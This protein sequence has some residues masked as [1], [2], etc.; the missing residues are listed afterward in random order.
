MMDR[1]KETL[2]SP[3]LDRTLEALKGQRSVR[4]LENY[5]SSINKVKEF[6]GNGWESLTMENITKCWTDKY[7]A[8]LESRH[9]DKPQTTDFYLRTFRAVYGHAL[10]LSSEGTD[11][12][13]F[14]GHRTGGYFPAKRALRKEEMQRLLSPDLRQ[15]LP[16]NQREA[17][18]VL[19]FILYARGMVFKD[20]YGL[21]WRM[22]TDGHIRYRRSKTDV[23]I[24]VEIVPELE[25]IMERYH[26]EDSPF[27]FPFLHETRKGCL[28]K[29]LPEESALRRI[30][31]TARMIGRK[32]GLSVPLTTYVLRH[33]WATL[34]LEDS[35]PVELISQCMG[36]TSI[37]T[38]QIYLSRISSHKVDIAVSGMYDRMLRKP[39]HKR[40]ERDIPSGHH[41]KSESPVSQ[42]MENG[43]THPY[44]SQ[45]PEN[46]KC[47]FLS[48]KE[49]SVSCHVNTVI[50][51]AAKVYISYIC[52]KFSSAFFSV[53]LDISSCL[54]V[55]YSFHTI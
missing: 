15:T 25:E 46:E 50:F 6:A 51:F 13:P 16:E 26:R 17:L 27:V 41:R 22:V 45:T 2:L 21:T 19:L 10:A 11:G 28:G 44:V 8:W 7:A 34:M 48:K 20:V 36:H 54:S 53:L 5:R 47:P 9:A 4:T 35:Q 43:N 33:T 52:S 14:G 30:N 24:D 55:L 40:K 18:D 49:T 23:P 31:R 12:K 29:E 38:T 42:P 39:K 37:R 32:A 1:K 3:L